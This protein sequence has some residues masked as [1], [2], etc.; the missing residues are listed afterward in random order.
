MLTIGRLA[1]QQLLNR[2]NNRYAPA[3][4]QHVS[5]TLVV[6]GTTGPVAPTT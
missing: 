6:R 4:R 2:I 5:A 3:N 1:A